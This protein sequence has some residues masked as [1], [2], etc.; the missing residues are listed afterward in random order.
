MPLASYV[1][2]GSCSVTS[3][4]AIRALV[5]ASQP[6][7]VDAGGLAD[8][9]ASAVGTD[10]VLCRHALAAGEPQL[11]PVVVLDAGR[12]PPDPARTGHGELVEPAGQDP[13]DVVLP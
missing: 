11:D 2:S 10:D 7:N 9:A 13:L 6:G 8:D 3:T 12:S 4:S 1:T 5:V